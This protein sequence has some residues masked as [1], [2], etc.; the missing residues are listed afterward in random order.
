MGEGSIP[1]SAWAFVSWIV[2][3]E[4]PRDFVTYYRKCI[5]WP[6]SFNTEFMKLLHHSSATVLF[7]LVNFYKTIDLLRW[8]NW[9]VIIAPGTT[10]NVHRLWRF[11]NT[12]RQHNI[13]CLAIVQDWIVHA[14]NWNNSKGSMMFSLLHSHLQQSA[15]SMTADDRLCVVIIWLKIHVLK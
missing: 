13:P 11:T 6:R 2:E 14:E 9:W 12:G 5:K 1:E 10:N 4:W 8:P 7:L 3:C 15:P